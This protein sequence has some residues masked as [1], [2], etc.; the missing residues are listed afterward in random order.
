MIIVN[1]TMQ[2]ATGKEKELEEILLELV[3]GTAT[4]EGAVE[5]RLHKF[6]DATG[7]YRFYEKF[8]DQKAFDFHCET[9]HFKTLFSKLGPLLAEEAVLDKLELI[10]SIPESK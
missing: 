7:K 1:A 8:K 9:D 2:A 4:E 3:K 5:Y 10:D 6:A